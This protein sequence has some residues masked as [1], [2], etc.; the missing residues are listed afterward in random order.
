MRLSLKTK[1][2]GSYILVALLVVLAGGIGITMASIIG[3]AGD[4]VAKN[5]SPIQSVVMSGAMS[6]S[7]LKVTLESYPSEITDLTVLNTALDQQLADFEMW[8]KIPIYGTESTEFQNSPEGANFKKLGLKIVVPKGPESVV[9]LAKKQEAMLKELN[10]LVEKT[11]SDQQSYINNFVVKVNGKSMEMSDFI[12]AAKLDFNDWNTELD[13][14]VSIGSAFTRTTDPAKTVLG[15][16]IYF[17]KN[18]DPEIAKVVNEFKVNHEKY[19]KMAVDVNNAATIDEGQTIYLKSKM[20]KTKIVNLFRKYDEYAN[21]KLVAIDVARKGSK[22][23]VAK[24]GIELSK[25]SDDVTKEVGLAMNKAVE[26]SG[27]AQSLANSVLVI[28]TLVALVFSILVGLGISNV[29]TRGVFGVS[30]VMKKVADGDLRDKAQVSSDDEIGDLSKDVNVM[31]NSL[32]EIVA[33]VK[34][35]SEKLGEA[36]TEIRTGSQQIAN[37]AQQQAA[38]FEELSSSVQ[39]NAE[40]VHKSNSIA[41]EVSKE[42]QEAGVAMGNTVEAISGIE[43]GSKQMAEAVELITDIA[44]QTNLLA[45][46]AAIEAARAGEHGKGFA[47]VADEVRQ[48]A[49]R[50]ATSAKEIQNL[51]KDNLRQVESGVKISKEA[52]DKTKVIMEGVKKIADQLQNVANATQEQAAAMEENASITEAN[53]TAVEHL[54]ALSETMSAQAEAMKELVAQFKIAGA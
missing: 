28:I 18:V 54:A 33:N 45:L 10:D 38:S 26:D 25:L 8:V 53:S 12:P 48:L 50:S 13:T 40:N 24:L 34:G 5:M 16:Y 49:E 11:K 20:I 29:I 47:V 15:Q 46:N 17:A 31:I 51:I 36:I 37:G 32:N 21:K 19:I 52:G 27:K 9:A 3:K 6:L 22:E 35:S 14:S 41:Q 23:R 1:L 39:A 44:D 4:V 43:K 42:A 30:T 2:I 7:Q